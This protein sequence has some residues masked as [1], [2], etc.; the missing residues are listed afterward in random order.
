MYSNQGGPYLWPSIYYQ[1]VMQVLTKKVKWEKAVLN[2]S[3]AELPSFKDFAERLKPEEDEMVGRR[4]CVFD[5]R[6]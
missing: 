1:L 3:M 4:D 5:L 2:H 6:D